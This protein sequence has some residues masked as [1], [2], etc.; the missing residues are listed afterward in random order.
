M[1]KKKPKSKTYKKHSL[2]KYWKYILTFL[3]IIVAPIIYWVAIKWNQVSKQQVN[4]GL[5]KPYQL[6]YTAFTKFTVPPEQ[7]TNFITLGLTVDGKQVLLNHANSKLLILDQS[8]QEILKVIL[9]QTKDFT[10]VKMAALSPVDMHTSY[11]ALLPE[12]KNPQ[13]TAKTKI[14]IYKIT[15]LPAKVNL[16]LVKT[17]DIPQLG[18]YISSA[19]PGEFW[20]DSIYSALFFQN[21]AFDEK[22]N[23]QPR[24]IADKIWKDTKGKIYFTTRIHINNDKS[25]KVTTIKTLYDYM[26]IY[27]GNPDYTILLPFAPLSLKRLAILNHRNN[28]IIEL[29]CPE[30]SYY[31]DFGF[32]G[33]DLI[34][35][36][37]TKHCNKYS[38]IQ[39][40]LATV[41]FNPQNKN[42]DQEID[43][44]M[45]PKNVQMQIPQMKD[46]ND[47]TKI[48]KYTFF[49]LGDSEFL[50]NANKS[51]LIDLTHSVSE[52]INL[53]EPD[54]NERYLLTVN[55]K[56]GYADIIVNN[57]TI[58]RVFKT[59]LK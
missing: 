1:S 29:N 43:I 4:K 9:G 26:P 14:F 34:Y 39:N 13:N 6:H 22:N 41:I 59:Q 57:A 38:N 51:M 58:L 44:K 37:D 8:G 2:L 20:V 55:N 11:L 45:L 42:K 23:S 33:S 10:S 27:W 49:K 47:A 5:S 15:T 52:K 53:I 36:L 19:R 31:T 12:L 46:L 17:I 54:A 7:N 35:I 25:I 40:G 30:T 24:P 21:T 50:I 48:N 28:T 18:Q 32:L 56:L 16:Q 3:L